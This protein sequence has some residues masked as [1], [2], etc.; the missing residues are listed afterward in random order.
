MKDDSPFVF[1]GLWEGWKDPATD[2]WLRTCTIITGEPNELV[3]QIHTRMP[4]ILPEEYHAKWLLPLEKFAPESRLIESEIRLDKASSSEF[5]PAAQDQI[6]RFEALPGDQNPYCDLACS[7]S[8]LR[9]LLW[10]T[11]H[12]S[13]RASRV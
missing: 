11:S 5:D 4:V 12:C 9:K 2:E 13:G 1:T 7:L 8:V 3:A 6:W 10:V